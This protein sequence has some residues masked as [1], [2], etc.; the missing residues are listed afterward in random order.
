MKRL[1][2]KPDANEYSNIYTSDMQKGGAGT[3]DFSDKEV[4]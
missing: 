2:P 3:T 4:I 1:P